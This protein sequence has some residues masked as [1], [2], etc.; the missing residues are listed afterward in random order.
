MCIV[1]FGWMCSTAR[2]LPKERAR[3]TFLTSLCNL[4]VTVSAQCLC[5]ISY[6]GRF[7]EIPVGFKEGALGAIRK[8]ETAQKVTQNRNIFFDQNRKPNF[9]QTI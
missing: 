9:L 8:R 5:G 4:S 7:S 2:F 1:P 3:I 6:F